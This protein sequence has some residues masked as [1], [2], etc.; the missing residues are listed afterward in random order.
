MVLDAWVAGLSGVV[1]GVQ[2]YKEIN[3]PLQVYSSLA[4][5]SKAKF[6]TPDF[7]QAIMKKTS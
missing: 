5:L 2:N 3:F 7:A 4:R 1:L 6:T